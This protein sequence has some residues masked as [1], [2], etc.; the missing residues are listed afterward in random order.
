LYIY[1][2]FCRVLQHFKLSSNLFQLLASPSYG[3]ITLQLYRWRNREP[4]R[5]LGVEGVCSYNPGTPTGLIR[6]VLDSGYL[7]R[8]EGNSTA[9]R[10]ASERGSVLAGFDLQHHVVVCQ[11]SRHLQ[12][13][14]T[15][16]AVYSPI[17]LSIDSSNNRLIH[18]H[19]HSFVR[20]LIHSS[21]PIG[22]GGGVG[23]ERK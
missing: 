18:L 12:H 3:I 15:Y 7:E 4:K 20:S 17:D 1:L 8:F 2:K 14:S 11:Y 16:T 5:K 9:K 10:V 21:C 6:L 22:Q 23:V 13:S 19:I